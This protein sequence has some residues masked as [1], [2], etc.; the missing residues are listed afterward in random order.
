MPKSSRHPPKDNPTPHT[1]TNIPRYILPRRPIHLVELSRGM[2]TR[3]EAILKAGHAVASYTWTDI[4]PDAHTATSHILARLHNRHPL[5]LPLEA[6]AGWDSRLPMDATTSTPEL[7][8]HAFPAEV[9]LIMTS[10]LPPPHDASTPTT[11]TP[12]TRAPNPRRYRSDKLLNSTPR[13][14]PIGRNRVWLGHTRRA[15]S[16]YTRPRNNGTVNGP[17]HPQMRIGSTPPH[18]HM[19]KPPA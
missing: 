9:D 15:P 5:L 13:P 6:M 1:L 8:T 10:P 2:A 4:D 18:S 16:P 17:K 14:D 3:L 7:F 19:V 11:G 12:G